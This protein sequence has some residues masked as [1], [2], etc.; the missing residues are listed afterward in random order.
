MFVRAFSVSPDGS[1]F[2]LTKIESVRGMGDV[3]QVVLF[4][5][6]TG[7]A[8]AIHLGAGEQLAAPVFRPPTPQPR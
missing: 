7:A 3:P 4:N 8:A 6:A 2:V 1:L 5:P